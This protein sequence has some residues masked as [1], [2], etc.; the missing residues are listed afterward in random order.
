LIA[1]GSPVERLAAENPC[2]TVGDLLL[3]IESAQVRNLYTMNY[4]ESQAYCDFLGQ[5]LAVR[6]NNPEHE[7]RQYFQNE[8]PW[9]AP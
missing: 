8:K 3:A 2:R 4:T 5:D 1:K 6:P 9:P 7:E